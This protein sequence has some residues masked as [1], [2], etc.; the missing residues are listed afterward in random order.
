MNLS[1]VIREASRI[2]IV[3]NGID[4]CVS[5]S[6]TIMR[7]DPSLFNSFSVLALIEAAILM[8]VAGGMDFSSSI[9]I[10]KARHLV[11]GSEKEWSIGEHKSTQI[12][13]LRYLMA[14]L[15]LL[16]EAILLSMFL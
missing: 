10:Q 6:L 2:V 7:Y 1:L 14:G 5:L 3:V 12:R 13:A 15:I 4:L 11:L 8:V 16:A 9:F